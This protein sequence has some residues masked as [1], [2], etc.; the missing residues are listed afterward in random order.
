MST[1][2][3]RD[4]MEKYLIASVTGS[5]EKGG[6]DLYVLVLEAAEA[7]DELEKIEDSGE[8]TVRALPRGKVKVAAED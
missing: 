8:S 2:A 4:F 5:G 3:K 1:N 6:V 7:W